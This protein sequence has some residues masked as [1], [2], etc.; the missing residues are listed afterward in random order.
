MED[1]PTNPEIHKIRHG[2]DSDEIPHLLDPLA[3]A[4]LDGADI[5]GDFFEEFNLGV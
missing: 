5:C 1:I 3:A 2:F 4:A